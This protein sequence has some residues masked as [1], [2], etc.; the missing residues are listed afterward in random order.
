MSNVTSPDRE[1]GPRAWLAPVVR[2]TVV[3]VAVVIAYFTLPFTAAFDLGGAV[4][5]AVGL[6]GISGLLL[7]QI[8]AIL[9]SAHPRAK[10]V[11]TIALIVPLFFVVFAAAYHVMSYVD[12]EGWS[13]QLSRLDSLYFTVTVFAT[14]GF[15]DIHAVSQTA[16][17][18]VTIQMI[19]NLVLIGLVTK[20]VVNAIQSGLARNRRD[21]GAG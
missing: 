13:E 10:G 11:E 14:V 19:A 21:D 20:V 12:A 1:Q 17:A 5:L 16:R 18:V 8:R 2:S 15:G 4:V 3:F 7:W 6:V 9:V